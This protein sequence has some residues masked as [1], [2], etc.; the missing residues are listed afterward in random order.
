MAM[1]IPQKKYS[2]G[3]RRRLVSPGY[4]KRSNAPRCIASR[5]PLPMPEDWK[6]WR[7]W[8]PKKKKAV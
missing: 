6:G 2:R 5:K 7:N 3:E 1:T 8:K 4:G